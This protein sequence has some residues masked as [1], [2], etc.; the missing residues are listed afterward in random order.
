MSLCYT[1]GVMRVTSRPQPSTRARIGA[2][3]LLRSSIPLVLFLLAGPIVFVAPARAEPELHAEVGAFLSAVGAPVE[4]N[5]TSTLG[6]PWFGA[7]AVVEVRGPGSP[8]SGGREWPV[9]A[10]VELPLGDREG[11]LAAV[12]DLSPDDLPA[13]GAYL[14]TARVTAGGGKSMSAEL[15]VG[16]VSNLPGSVDLAVMWPLAFG[17]HRDLQGAFVDDVVQRAVVPQADEEGS[18]FGLFKTIDEYPDWR[19]TLAIEP[20]LLA[21]IRDLADGFTTSPAA[22]LTQETPAGD[23]TAAFAEQALVTLR[24]VASLDTVQVIPGPYALP[25][26][27][28]LAREGWDDGFEQMQLGKLELQSTL[29]LSAIPDAAYSPGLDIT[30][31]S[32]GAFSRASIDYVVARADVT[33]DLAEAPA[34]RRRPVRVQGRENE[35]LTLVLADEEL[36]AALAPPWDIGRF[37]AALAATLAGGEAGGPLVAAPADEYAHPPAA[38]LRELGRLLASTPWIRTMTLEDVLGDTPP[39]TRPIFLSR[40]GGYVEGYTARSHLDG[41]REAHAAVAAL[42]GAADSDRAPLDSLRRLLFEAESRYWFVPG[43]DPAVAN[44]GL[45]YVE[46]VARAVT[47]EF[48]K[49]DVAGDKSVIVVGDEGRV[50]VAVVNQTGYPLKVRIALAGDGIDFKDGA[51]MEVSL[52]LQ[53]TIFDVPVVLSKGRTVMTVVIEAGDLAVDTETIQVRSI[54]V[55]PVVAWAVAIVGLLVLIAWA[56]LRLR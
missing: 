46:A 35:R 49:V 45:S 40:Y 12:L 26:L 8:M 27:P 43:V 21:Q 55:G 30:T 20:L 13:P 51:E 44:L 47:E 36:R 39:E 29:Q 5:L 14:L 3:L 7:V 10:R 25:A 1:S 9:A 38:Y 33:R 56:M 23:K 32:L 19:M 17:S 31:D 24:D 42:A 53:E 18:L 11:E 48:D 52:G 6:G 50:P 37:A 2:V 41:L 15:W 34:D 54:A 22:D 28:V 4:V 16:R